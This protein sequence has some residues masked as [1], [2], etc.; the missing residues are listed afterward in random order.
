MLISYGVSRNLVSGFISYDGEIFVHHMKKV[1]RV[2]DH[3]LIFSRPFL[4]GFGGIFDNGSL[5]GRSLCIKNT[6]QDCM[7]VMRIGDQVAPLHGDGW[8]IFR[9]WRRRILPGF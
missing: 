3:C 4:L 6:L 2:F 7:L 9:L 1:E 8:W 5:C